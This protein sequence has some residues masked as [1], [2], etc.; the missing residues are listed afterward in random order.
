MIGIALLTAGGIFF[1]GLVLGFLTGYTVPF[2]VFGSLIG[3]VLFFAL[4]IP[5][6]KP[7]SNGIKVEKND[8]K[9][10]DDDDLFITD[11]I[12]GTSVG[13]WNED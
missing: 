13:V 1:T 5:N 4:V 10:F 11:E 8:E 3:L 7:N 12:T 9:L 2:I 6:I